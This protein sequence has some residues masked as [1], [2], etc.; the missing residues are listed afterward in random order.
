MNPPSLSEPVNIYVVPQ[1]IIVQKG[2][3]PSVLIQSLTRPSFIIKQPRIPFI[4]N[5][6]RWPPIIVGKPRPP[7]II[8][9]EPRE[10]Y[11]FH[12]DPPP[13]RSIREPTSRQRVI[14]TE[15]LNV[16]A[17][18]LEPRQI[19]W[20]SPPQKPTFVAERRQPVFMIN[21]P[22]PT[23]LNLRE[24][25]RYLRDQISNRHMVV[26]DKKRIPVR[27]VEDVGQLRENGESDNKLIIRTI[28]K[29]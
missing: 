10:N 8:F 29:E 9:E 28:E 4:R 1:Q 11:P 13:Q 24:K 3:Q 27:F 25:K 17:D 26:N 7:E 18:S 12:I 5:Q 15:Q 21:S 6:S 23:P 2:R 20:I 14:K 19:H 16:V 22:L